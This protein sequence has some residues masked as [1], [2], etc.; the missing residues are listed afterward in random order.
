M[1]RSKRRKKNSRDLI[2]LSRNKTFQQNRTIVEIFRDVSRRPGGDLRP[3][4]GPHHLGSVLQ[5]PD[6]DRRRPGFRVPLHPQGP[7]VVLANHDP[8][9]RVQAGV[10]LARSPDIGDWCGSGNGKEPSKVH[11]SSCRSVDP[12]F[13]LVKVVAILKADN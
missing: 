1:R 12:A 3:Q 11:H 10:H 13:H 4:R 6:H 9:H 5:P 7:E 8:D 2:G